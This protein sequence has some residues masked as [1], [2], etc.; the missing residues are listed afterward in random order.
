MSGARQGDGLLVCAA[1]FLFGNAII[2]GG[3]R[4][5]GPR[6]A[7]LAGPV[8][9]LDVLEPDEELVARYSIIPH[10]GK[11]H[12]HACRFQDFK[13]EVRVHSVFF[14]PYGGTGFKT[15]EALAVADWLVPHGRLIFLE[16]I[17]RDIP[18]PGEWVEEYRLKPF[19][20]PIRI[21]TMRRLG[22]G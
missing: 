6:A 17:H 5:V 18:W 14:D 19:R 21:A 9:R 16:S 11:L 15:K 22:N 4:F 8:T 1:S 20:H 7:L 2:V 13:P 12:V 10:E 3:G